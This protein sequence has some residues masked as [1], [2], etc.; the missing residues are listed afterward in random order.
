MIYK[1]RQK[2]DQ[3]YQNDKRTSLGNKEVEPVQLDQINTHQIN[4][5]TYG[6]W[7]VIIKSDTTLQV[8]INKLKMDGYFLSFLH[9]NRQLI[10]IAASIDMSSDIILQQ[11][12][13]H[14]ICKINVFKTLPGFFWEKLCQDCYFNIYQIN[15]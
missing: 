14:C 8:F 6:I 12:M 3:I 7:K 4:T 9:V 15:R 5:K 1:S 11:Q 2:N 13:H 10:F